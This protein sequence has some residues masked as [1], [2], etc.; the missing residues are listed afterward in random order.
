MKRYR[1]KKSFLPFLIA[2]G[3]IILCFLSFLLARFI[4]FEGSFPDANLYEMLFWGVSVTWLLLC[5]RFDF[6][7]FPRILFIHKIVSKNIYIIFFYIFIV[8][9]SLFIV[10]TAEFS[11]AFLGIAL[12]FFSFSQ[13]LWRVFVI[14]FLRFYRKKGH[15]LRKVL[16]VG[17]NNENMSNLIEKVY[18]NPEYGYKISGLFTDV[19]DFCMNFSQCFKGKLSEVFSFLNKNTVDE[20]VISLSNRKSELINNLLKFSDNNL[21]R[22]SIVPEFSE[23]LSHSFSIDYI[24]NVPIMKI[25]KE[26]LE[27]LSNRVFKRFFDIMFSL[28]TIVFIFSWLFPIIVIIIKITSRGPVFFV[29][30]RTGKK[31][32]PFRCYKFRSMYV[33]KNSDTLQVTKGDVRITPFGAFMRRTSIDE[34]PQFF[35]VLF[36]HMSLIGPRPHMLKHT[37]EYRGLVDKFM[38]RHFAKPG[39]TGWAQVN[40][41]RGEIKE[42]T[43]MVNR[44][45]ADIWYIENWS[46]LLDLKIIFYTTR[47]MLFAKDKNAY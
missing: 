10:S 28:A 1:Y 42:V 27:V 12:L 26:P 33:N 6:Y 41:F 30:E 17:V 45:K 39:V 44:A 43:D 25:R 3:D 40:G 14:V 32:L 8:A 9:G 37:E 46:F 23:H 16:I 2:L 11:K 35:N 22:V 31:G 7:N 4:V 13:I 29:Q 19:D 24:Q 15:N 47:L 36:N 21:I 5:L 20:I 38:V 34:F 18:L